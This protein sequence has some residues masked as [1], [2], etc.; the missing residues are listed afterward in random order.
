MDVKVQAGAV[1]DGQ[2]AA[3]AGV[4]L[5]MAEQ[6]A[7]KAARNVGA[8]GDEVG[9][10]HCGVS[11]WSAGDVIGVAA[12]DAGALVSG[13]GAGAAAV[14]DGGAQGEGGT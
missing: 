3:L 1:L 13:F 8:K 9:G 5:A 4:N 6:Q 11:W 14:A 2:A 10:S 12:L 7:A